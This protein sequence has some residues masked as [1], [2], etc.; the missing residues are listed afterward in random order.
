MALLQGDPQATDPLYHKIQENHPHFDPPTLLRDRVEDLY[1]ICKD[2]LDRK[3]TSQIKHNF[4]SCY[5]EL[6]FCTTF[7]KRLDLRVTHPSDQ[8]PDYYLP[9]IDCW[10]EIVTLTN[11]D[12]DN[13]NSISRPPIV[14]VSS[15][16]KDQI[17]LRITNSFTYKAEKVFEYIRKGLVKDSQRIIICINGGWLDAFWRFPSYAVG[18]FPQVVNALLPIGNMVLN[19]DKKD[20]TIV[21]RTFE[22]CDFVVKKNNRTGSQSI[23]TGYFVD[24]KYARISAVVYSYANVTDSIETNDLGRDFYII[25]NPLAK[26][27]LPVGS[28]KCGTEYKIETDDNFINITPIEY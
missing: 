24:P 17:V 12:R 1:N 25:H 19:M 16:P 18:G 10:A 3:F 26:H 14:A 20:M 22:S 28:F 2:L 4:A 23:K 11:G 7:L 13:P 27:P 15:F 5:S 8:G 6:Y 9:D 21:G